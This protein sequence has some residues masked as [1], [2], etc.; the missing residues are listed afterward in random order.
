MQVAN[1]YRLEGF[2]TLQELYNLIERSA[3]KDRLATAR[4]YGLALLA[5]SPIAQGVLSEKY[6]NGTPGGTRAS[7]ATDISKNYLNSQTLGAV[8]ALNEMAK[9]KGVSLPQFALAWLLH[10]Q[11]DLGITIVPLLGI[12]STKYLEEALGALDMRLSTDE[13]KRAE[14][15]SQKAKVLPW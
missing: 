7:Y 4:K 12:T 13:M 8:R 15:I 1:D 2:V 11:A 10:K 14:E 5:Y 6:L 9:Q 3:E